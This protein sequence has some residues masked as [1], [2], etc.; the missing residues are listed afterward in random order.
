MILDWGRLQAPHP[1][2]IFEVAD[3]FL[4]F[5]VDAD[6]WQRGAHKAFFAPGDA[7]KLLIPLLVGC[8]ERFGVGVQGI[9]QLIEQ[10][11]HGSGTD[12]DVQ[13]PQL[14]SDLHQSFA[15]PQRVPAGGIAGG[16]LL[17]QAGQCLQETGRFFSARGR[18]PPG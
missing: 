9:A 11:P 7:L 6:N 13:R 5:G 18:P 14:P 17:Q 15:C 16:I 1:A 10:P 3:Q 12:C 2:G 4:L 8:G